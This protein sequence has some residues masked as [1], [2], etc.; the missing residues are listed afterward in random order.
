VVSH[1]GILKVWRAIPNTT[2]TS[3]TLVMAFGER[4]SWRTNGR[5]REEE[6]RFGRV[7]GPG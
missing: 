2:Y 6:K 5:E 7:S 4:G 3:L 1:R